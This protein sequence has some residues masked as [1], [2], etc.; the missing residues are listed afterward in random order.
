MGSQQATF[1]TVYMGKTMD[2]MAYCHYCPIPSQDP[3]TFCTHILHGQVLAL[4]LPKNAL[5]KNKHNGIYIYIFIYM[6][7]AL[8]LG[9]HG[10]HGGAGLHGFHGWHG[11]HGLHWFLGVHGLLGLH[12][13]LPGLVVGPS[14]GFVADVVVS[15]VVAPAW[16]QHHVESKKVV[17]HVYLGKLLY[18]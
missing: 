12:L 1:E 18:G 10:S 2:K 7:H 6:V 3:C 4:V 11:L 15:W 13:G 9:L 8:S 14:K 17:A 16:K 5:V